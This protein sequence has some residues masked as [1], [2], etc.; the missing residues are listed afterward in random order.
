MGINDIIAKINVLAQKKRTEGLSE[1][2]QIEQ[3]ALYSEYLGFIRNQVKQ[4][5]DNIETI[6]E[7]NIEES[8]KH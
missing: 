6:D 8:K 3:K 7:T 2:E 5:L 1:A 4:Q